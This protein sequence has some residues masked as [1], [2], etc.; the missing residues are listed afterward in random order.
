[1]ELIDGEMWV[2]LDIDGSGDVGISDLAAVA[3]DW[4]RGI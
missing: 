1:L 2:G 3:E 4:L